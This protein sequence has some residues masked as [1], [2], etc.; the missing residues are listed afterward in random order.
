MVIGC[1][2]GPFC[3]TNQRAGP[4]CW[5][6]R[7]LFEFHHGLIDQSDYF[8]ISPCTCVLL[9]ISPWF[10]YGPIW[11][12]QSESSMI[13]LTNQN[14]YLN[15]TILCNKGW[16]IR[17]KIYWF[18]SKTRTVNLSHVSMT[19]DLSVCLF[20]SLSD[21]WWA[22]LSVDQSV[23]QLSICL[24]LD[25]LILFAGRAHLCLFKSKFYVIWFYDLLTH[26]I[27]AEMI[28]WQWK[29]SGFSSC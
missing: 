14:F 5:P 19:V 26:M 3:L 28:W 10:L 2:M 8:W 17:E 4:V 24:G 7:I 11:F 25:L 27:F 6:I 15:F 21:C 20:I 12:D 29:F 23:S 13:L 22:S 9:W 1:C 18:V 16:Y